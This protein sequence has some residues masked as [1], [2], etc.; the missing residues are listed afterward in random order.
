MTPVVLVR[1]PIEHHETFFAIVGILQIFWVLPMIRRWG[2]PWYFVGIAGNAILIM[3][4]VWTRFSNPITGVGMPI[5]PLEIHI[6]TIVSQFVY[7]I[8]ATIIVI[9][10]TIQLKLLKPSGT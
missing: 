2:K 5:N 6:T 10:E 1:S 3:L 4:Y 7:I 9:H 8:V